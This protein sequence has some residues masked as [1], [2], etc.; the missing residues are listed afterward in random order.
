MAALI[1]MQ[2]AIMRSAMKWRKRE[3]SQS[4]RTSLRVKVG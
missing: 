4:L 1:Q 3:M 2:I